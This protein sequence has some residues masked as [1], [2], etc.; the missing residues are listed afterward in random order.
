MPG[1]VLLGCG[2]VLR[3]GGLVLRV[4]GL[5]LLAADV[6]HLLVPLSPDSSAREVGAD[7]RSQLSPEGDDDAADGQGAQEGT[8]GDRGRPILVDLQQKNG[9]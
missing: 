4:G 9:A 5:V 2:L 6:G 1:V 8:Q 7:G 3:V